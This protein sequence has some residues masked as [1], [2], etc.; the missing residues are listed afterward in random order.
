MAQGYVDL[1]FPNPMGPNDA[2]I[3]IYGYTLSLAVAALGIALFFI[4]FMLHLWLVVRYRTWYFIPLVVGTVLEVAG[5]VFRLLSS[6]NDP[7]S[8]PWF[9][10]QYF[11]IV[12]A[13]VFF[14]AA[15][16]TLV[17]VLINAYGKE[18]APLP[19]KVVLGV[20][21]TFDIVATLIQIAGAALVGV[22]YS[23][24]KDPTTPSN[25][26]LAGLSIQVASFAVFLVVLAWTLFR[27][28]RSP[29]SVSWVFFTTLIVATLAVYLWT[30]FRLA[31]G[32]EG[33]ME[34]LSTHEVYFGCLEFA[35]VVVAIYLLAYGHPGRF[36]G[37]GNSVIK[38]GG[39]I[40]TNGVELNGFR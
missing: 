21:I 36:C 30:C 23:N 31:E 11:C 15:I 34:E 2:T 20:F 26:L 1:N 27:T 32:A 33:L 10:V 6:Q 40:P 19:P 37:H 35:P 4:A 39:R 25:V 13:P 7:Y 12:V 9:I 3:V 5:Y 29:V 24:Q 28:K 8:V 18:H 14:S 16:Y 38:P 17:S 22:A